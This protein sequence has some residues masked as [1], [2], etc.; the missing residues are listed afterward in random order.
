MS[1]KPANS[2]R[3]LSRDDIRQTVTMLQAIAL[4]RE[5]FASLSA[6]SVSVP[7]RGSVEMAPDRARG[8]IMPVYSSAMKRYGVK[9]VTLTDGNPVRGLPFIQGLMIVFDSETGTPLGLMDAGFVTALRTGAASGLATDLLA[10]RDASVAVIFGAGTQARTQLEGIAGV[11]DLKKVYVFSLNEG[12]SRTFAGEMEARLGVNVVATAKRDVVS[13]ADIICTATTSK[14]PV[15]RDE[16]LK[17]GVH[18]NG[19]GSYKPE[20]REIPGET[21]ARGTVVVDSRES[22]LSEAGDLI[23]P[24]HQGLFKRESL[25]GEI[26]EVVL[27]KRRGRSTSDEITVFKS[28]GNAVQDLALSAAILKEAERLGLGVTTAI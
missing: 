4:M 13:E 8:L 3:V 12:D 1:P 19:I 7:V 26:G 2:V 21:I 18:I 14:E 25:H 20:A 27:G 23:I 17:A 16:D 28:V 6:G 5:A 15:F 10:R 9:L 11:R 22:A 24:M